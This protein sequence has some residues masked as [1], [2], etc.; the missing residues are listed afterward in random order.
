MNLKAV[1]GLLLVLGL[2][3]GGVGGAWVWKK[4][5]ASEERGVSLTLNTAPSFE[6]R[7]EIEKKYNLLLDEESFLQ[8]IV[9]EMSLISFYGVQTESQAVELLKKRS[10]VLLKKDGVTIWVVHRAERRER[11]LNDRLGR[12]LGDQ[13]VKQAF[14]R[15]PE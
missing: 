3:V 13:L 1:I 8:T 4:W 9:K 15:P 10:R 5:T 14:P 6:Q 11:E 7:P 2:I 12:M